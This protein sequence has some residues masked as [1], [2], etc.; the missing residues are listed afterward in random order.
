MK[1]LIYQPRCSYYVG[2][3]EIVPLEQAKMLSK[4][5]H[6]VVLLTAKIKGLKKSE[7]FRNFIL[8]NPD[9]KIEYVP[10]D[11]ELLDI[12]KTEAGMN[13]KRWDLESFHVGLRARDMISKLLT[14][15]FLCVVHYNVDLIAIPS[16]FKHVLHLHGYPEKLSYLDEIVLYKENN[17]I[18]VSK[19]IKNKWLKLLNNKRSF[20]D[21]IYN[22]IDNE[23][24]YNINIFKKYDTGYIGR[25]IEI[26]GIQ[27]VIDA[28]KIIRDEKNKRISFAIAGT[29]PYESELKRIVKE[30]NLES[31][32][33]F[34][35]YLPDNLLVEFYNSCCISVL[36][37]YN[38][39]GVLTTML[40]SSACGTP[41][42]STFNTSMSEFI[43]DRYNGILVKKEDS[44][45]ISMA[46]LE[47]LN[48]QK[49]KEIGNNAIKTV[50]ER[51]LWKSQ[52]KK[53]SEFYQSILDN[54]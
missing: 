31:Q 44:R 4:M 2:G 7:V 28:I 32:I 48:N 9:I 14:N 49:Y 13:K 3:G 27:H 6:K 38:K 24:F 40:E 8:N 54:K 5:G 17:F 18:A 46:I 47:L 37:S 10:V 41:V 11:G 21:V 39:E 34:L 12:Y 22:G 19:L 36:P 20:I 45:D 52:A 30:N 53:L 15:D 29:G 51:W 43:E 25:L 33:N 35:G 26:K 23:R 1:I 42:I 50:Q 16:G